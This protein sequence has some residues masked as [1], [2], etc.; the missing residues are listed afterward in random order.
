LL[1]IK[2]RQDLLRKIFVKESNIVIFVFIKPLLKYPF[3]TDKTTSQTPNFCEAI[4]L[5]FWIF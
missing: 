5:F 3:Y 2:L 4:Y 1:K